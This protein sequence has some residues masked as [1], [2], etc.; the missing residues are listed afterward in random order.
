MKPLENIRVL[1]FTRVL[2]GPT[3]TRILAELGAQ[4][5]K[6]EPPSGDIGRIAAPQIQGQ[7]AYYLQLNGG[8]RNLSIDLNWPEAREAVLKLCHKADVIV[9]NFRPGT[10]KTF[11]LDYELSL[12]HI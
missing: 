11:G 8:K 7:S 9:E 6:V 3:C 5:T 1:D 10:M 12:I 2:A 4:V